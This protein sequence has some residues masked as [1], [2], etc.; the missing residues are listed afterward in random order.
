MQT[1][2]RFIKFIPTRP[3]ENDEYH[4]AAGISTH[5]DRNGKT[6]S[7]VNVKPLVR[8]EGRTFDYAEQIENK[9]VPEIIRRARQLGSRTIITTVKRP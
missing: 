2:D 1:L 4:V 6:H 9:E 5:R 7:S 3:L 8:L